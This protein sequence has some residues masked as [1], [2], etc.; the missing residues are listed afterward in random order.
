MRGLT[1]VSAALFGATALAAYEPNFFGNVAAE[2]AEKKDDDDDEDL[3][4]EEEEPKEAVVTLT[5]DTWEAAVKDNEKLIIEFYA[6]WCGHC[7]SLAPEYEGAAQELKK[8]KRKTVLAKVDATVH[9]KSAAAHGVQGYP[10]LV[11]YDGGVKQEYNGPRQKDGIVQWV[12]KREKSALEVCTEKSFAER[13]EANAE[14][15]YVVGY[16]KKKSGGHMALKKAAQKLFREDKTDAMVICA[17]FLGKDKDDKKDRKLTMFKTNATTVLDVDLESSFSGVWN[18]EK[19]SDWIFKS[20]YPSLGVFDMQRY[21]PDKIGGETPVVYAYADGEIDEK[22]QKL[23]LKFGQQKSAGVKLAVMDLKA[24]PST[25][26]N[27]FAIGD[28]TKPHLSSLKGSGNDVKKYIFPL[29]D[30]T[31]EKVFK[32]IEDVKSGSAKPHYKS[33]PAPADPKENEVTIITG[34]NWEEIVMSS[35]KD[36]MVEYYAP[37]CGHC[38]SLQPKYDELAGKMK[39]KGYDDKV[40]IGKMDAT[41]NESPETV[42]GFPK[43]VFYPAVKN[44]MKK[45]MEYNGAREMQ[46][47]YDFIVENA[48]TLEGMEPTIAD[49]PPSTGGKKKKYGMVERELERKRKAAEKAKAEL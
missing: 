47:M 39:Q 24:D 7:K 26:K 36:V 2:E 49:A 41:A 29:A 45:K 27:A 12:E 17:I 20:T 43:L 42:T 48:K 30:Y 35:K 6:P 34:D 33:A 8:R 15:F 38:K 18:A 19:V 37:W 22:V 13:K 3:D 46:N 31:E 10:T 40:V 9:A 21:H 32:W 25:A 14:K 28:V 23:L 5:D 11:Y 16:V 44:P 1:R 4:A